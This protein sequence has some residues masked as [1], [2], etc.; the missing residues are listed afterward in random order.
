MK[1]TTYIKG[2]KMPLAHPQSRKITIRDF[3]REILTDLPT[4]IKRS[5]MGVSY[6]DLQE[7]YGESSQRIARA[8]ESLIMDDRIERKR[9]AGGAIYV[10]P[11][12][13]DTPRPFPELPHLQYLLLVHLNKQKD[14]DNMVLTNYFKLAEELG[15]SVGGTKNAVQRL[16]ELSHIKILDAYNEHNRKM[17]ILISTTFSD[18]P[19]T[20]DD[21]LD[22]SDHDTDEGEDD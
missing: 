12:G 15:H 3:A 2:K 16:H 21:N 11:K 8:L 9:R 22:N 7:Y 4:L 20:A 6:S 13:Y 19:D 14:R 17:P 10:I 5:P 1:H 18:L